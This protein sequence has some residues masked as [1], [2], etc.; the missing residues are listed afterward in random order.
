VLGLRRLGLD[1]WFVEQ[2]DP[3]TC[4]DDAGAPVSIECSSNL[5]WFQS[6]VARFGLEHRAVLLANDGRSLSGLEADALVDIAGGC[7]A[8]FNI[9]GNLTFEPLLRRPRVR[10]YV[11]LD[12]GYTQIWHRGGSLGNALERHESLLTVALA[13]HTPS[14]TIP[15]DGLRWRPVP[16]PVVLEEWPVCAPCDGLRLTTVAAWRGGYGRL[17]HQGQRYGQKAHEFRRFAPVPRRCAATFEAALKIDPA[18]ERDAQLLRRGG[19]RL[20]DPSKVAATP[21]AFRSYV[22]ESW[23][24]FSPAQG[25][26]AQMRSG[27]FSDRTARYLACGR[28]AIIQRTGAG[29]TI[30]EGEGILTF[31]TPDDAAAAVERLLNDYDTHACAARRLAEDFLDSDAVL[32]SVLEEVLG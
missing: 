9:S 28:P 12:P 8:L 7:D 11:D 23:G 1:V 15:T 18:D 19:W 20:V 10:A 2:I 4:R 5:R 27:W 17:V 24:E 14:C 31:A 26:Y 6:V 32:G 3:G 25:I 30:P 21:D 16:P 22:R 13:I 29:R